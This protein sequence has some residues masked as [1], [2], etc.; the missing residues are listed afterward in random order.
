M[1]GGGRET[2]MVCVGEGEGGTRYEMGAADVVVDQQ[3]RYWW[4][5]RA[6]MAGWLNE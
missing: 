6:P 1:V 5:Q 3:P 2:Y 4:I